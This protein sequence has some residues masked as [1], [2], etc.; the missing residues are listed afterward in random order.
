MS[1]IAPSPFAAR[2]AAC[3]ATQACAWLHVVRPTFVGA[4]I[5]ALI[6]WVTLGG[7]GIA[8][9]GTAFGSAGAILLG[10]V[11]AFGGFCFAVGRGRKEAD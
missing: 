10:L 9:L 4:G 1:K 5:G 2:V 6:G 8:L 11:G 7:V 3:A